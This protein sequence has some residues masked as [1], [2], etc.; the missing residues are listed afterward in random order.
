MSEKWRK[1]KVYKVR[2]LYVTVSAK[3]DIRDGKL[4]ASIRASAYKEGILLGEHYVHGVE[5][6]GGVLD[7]DAHPIVAEAM[8]YAFVAA[9]RNLHNLQDVLFNY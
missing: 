7:T 5:F 9:A 3:P 6:P 8:D 4:C 2:Y 1:L